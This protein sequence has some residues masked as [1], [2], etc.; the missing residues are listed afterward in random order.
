MYDLKPLTRDAIPRALEKAER[1]RLLNEPAE[2]ESICED[3]LRIDPDNREALVHLLLALTE[4]FDDGA[5]GHLGTARDIVRRLKDPYDTE[6][7]SG[8]I[9]E[10]HA[11]ALL[12]TGGIGAGR[13]AQELLSEAMGHYHAA[14]AVK[15]IGNDD[16]ILRWNA[17][18]RRLMRDGEH[19]H[20]PEERFEPFLE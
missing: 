11:K 2:A 20:R 5:G 4:Q 17:C 18:A 19:I 3:V 16:A 8:L 6:Y 12:R 14:E 15:P 1:Y 13:M 7:Y 9:S 10:R